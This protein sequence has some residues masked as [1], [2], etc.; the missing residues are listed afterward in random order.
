MAKRKRFL[1]AATAGVAG[2]AAVG[3]AASRR[4][5]SGKRASMG[6]GPTPAKVSQTA[7]YERFT[8]DVPS[9]GLWYVV[10]RGD[11]LLGTGA[12][13][14]TW[15]ALRGCEELSGAPHPGLVADTV[16]ARVAYAGLI[17]AANAQHCAPADVLPARAY[18]GPDGRG[19]EPR[20][21]MRLW[22]PVLDL[23]AIG[24][25]SVVPMRWDDGSDWRLPPPETRVP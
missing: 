10:R 11:L 2:V 23:D 18:R 1:L 16:A 17:C 3:L 9:A 12:R 25:G 7:L 8:A 14:I 15:T 4:D 19:L 21:G 22:L 20:A 6:K 24:S 5:A 13:S